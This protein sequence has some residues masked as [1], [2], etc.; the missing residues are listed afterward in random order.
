MYR[1]IKGKAVTIIGSL[2][3][4]AGVFISLCRFINIQA[5]Q[6]ISTSGFDVK[7]SPA[8]FLIIAGIILLFLQYQVLK[9]EK[10]VLKTIEE[11]RSAEMHTLTEKLRNCKGDYQALIEQSFDAIYILDYNGNFIDANVRLCKMTGYTRDELL[12]LNIT[13]I[14]DPEQLKTDPFIPYN[15]KYDEGIIRERRLVR[16]NGE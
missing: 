12:K 15:S 7:I 11:E 3:I 16:K 2:C 8:V 4:G 13:G 9:Y 5:F 14:I 6:S 10:R 1:L